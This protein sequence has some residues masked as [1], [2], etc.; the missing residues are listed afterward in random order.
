VCANVAKAWGKRRYAAAFVSKL[1]DSEVESAESQVWLDLS[2]ACGYISEAASKGLYQP[3]DFVLGK[4][5]NM[6]R[7]S[8]QGQPPH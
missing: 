1:S 6:I 7:Q 4:L 8:E 5:V 3:Y 2:L